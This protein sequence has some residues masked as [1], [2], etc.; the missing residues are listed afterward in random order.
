MPKKVITPK[1]EKFIRENRL[2]MSSAEIAKHIGC[3]KNPVQNYIRDNNLQPPKHIIKKF[4]SLAQK[5]RTLFTQEETDFVKNNYLNL[6][7]RRIAAKLN[8]SPLSVRIRMSQL[9]LIV[10]KEIIEERKL[11]GR[12]KK[13][14]TPH[15]KGKKIH[16][17]MSK[18][19][20]ESFRKHQFK[21]GH[22]PHNFIDFDFP[23][24]V[25]HLGTPKKP[26]KYI[27]KENKEWEPY[28]RYLYKKHIGP[29]SDN[30]L[31]RFKD[32]DTLNC[33]I[34]NLE[35]VSYAE[36]GR[37]TATDYHALPNDLKKTIKIKNKLIKTVKD[38]GKQ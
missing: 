5:G 24:R 14:D 35:A 38:Y 33:D 36:N 37:R 12:F 20:A 2:N 21:K 29:I 31:I 18:E 32:G 27:R 28:N 23:I 16:Q 4:R 13:G 22:I 15:N 7:V 9:G 19:G 1:W 34:G 11:I 8:K 10:P 17:F 25:K 3:S 6:P 30:E 26:Y